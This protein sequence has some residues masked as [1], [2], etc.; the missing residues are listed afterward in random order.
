MDDYVNS[1]K[2]ELEKHVELDGNDGYCHELRCES[3]SAAAKA[4]H[5]QE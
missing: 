5:G 3:E 2:V 1:R 4:N